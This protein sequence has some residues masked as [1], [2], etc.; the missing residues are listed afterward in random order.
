MLR[1]TQQSFQETTDLH[2]LPGGSAIKNLPASAGDPGDV[3]SSGREGPLEKEGAAH[4][5]ILPGNSHAQRSP[6]GYSPR[7]HRK[8]AVTQRLN[9]S[10]AAMQAAGKP[11]EREKR[12]LKGENC[13]SSLE[14][15]GEA[16]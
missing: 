3:G 5:S 14:E 10:N 16:T 1:G 15:N 11:R 2:G 7:G 6:A 9:D 4:S 8:S 13:Q 12:Y